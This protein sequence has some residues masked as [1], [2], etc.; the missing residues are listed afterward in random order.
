MKKNI[1]INL[2]GSLYAID[3]DAYELL[4]K[5]EENMCAYFSR[6]EGG[7]E[8]ADD[9]RHR[10][11]ELFAELKAAGVQAITISHVEDII[12]RIGNPEEMDSEKQEEDNDEEPAP[13]AG[14]AEQPRCRRKFFRSAD[15]VMIAGVM[16]GLSRYMGGN[17]P[18]PWRIALV[19]LTIFSS[20]FFAIAYLVVWGAVPQ[21][22]TA[23]E[24][25]QMNGQPVNPKNLNE[26]IMRN[27]HRA[28]EYVKSTDVK[29][30]ASGCL[31]TLLSL[32]VWCMKALLLMVGIGIFLFVGIALVGLFLAL[33][34]VVIAIC[35][36][37]SKIHFLEE[38][39]FSEYLPYM[40]GFY[41]ELTIC[42]VAG[43]V[44][45]SLLLYICTHLI[46]NVFRTTSP[47]S[48]VKRFTLLITWLICTAVFVALAT[49]LSAQANSA[50]KK[51]DQERNTVN[52]VY[53]TSRSWG[54]LQNAGWEVL[55]AEGCNSDILAWQRNYATN[56]GIHY[57]RL[58]QNYDSENRR[59]GMRLNLRHRVELPAGVYR[60]EGLASANGRGF[61]LYA[62]TGG[63]DGWTQLG[64]VPDGNDPT[65]RLSDVTWE[66]RAE[67]PMLVENDSAR[68]N[69]MRDAYG[70]MHYVAVDNIFH[71][72]G[73]IYYGISN[74]VSFTGRP[75]NGDRVSL[76]DLR[77]VRVSDLPLTQH[78]KKNV[79]AD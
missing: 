74:D 57:L 6:R 60:L 61:C 76:F 49:F 72:G 53:L 9:I 38:M 65:G 67:V 37:A 11:A 29:R 26:E 75:W 21:A 62:S 25:L 42:I 56:D 71:N 79:S 20:G 43:I 59:K 70:W 66:R 77:L 24:R 31:S 44:S 28:S 15:D 69:E 73:E 68:W 17:D 45:F 8:I 1:T 63:G 78:V 12:H 32:L 2:F 16:A 18:L 4:K 52:G 33:A 27:F 39:N 46:A 51:F 55:K 34:T 5:Y 7:E 47:F 3:E 36:G 35:F 41:W 23:E 54:F 14:P 30:R 19:L 40:P 22:R 48:P 13:E 50:G 58:S 10:V 64:E